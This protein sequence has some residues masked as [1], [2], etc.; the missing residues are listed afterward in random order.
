M[1]FSCSLSSATTHKEF[2]IWLSFLCAWSAFHSASIRGRLWSPVASQRC[3]GVALRN[4]VFSQFCKVSVRMFLNVLPLPPLCMHFKSV[5]WMH[6][7]VHTFRWYL[8][9]QTPGLCCPGYSVC[10]GLVLDAISLF[11]GIYF[12]T[13]HDSPVSAVQYSRSSLAFSSNFCIW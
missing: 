11:Y 4:G 1:P 3:L 5:S 13:Q 2:F 10:L 9:S 8:Y 6:L 12:L 7:E